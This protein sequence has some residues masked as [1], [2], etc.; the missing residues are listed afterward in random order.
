M[1]V[2]VSI[3][4]AVARSRAMSGQVRRQA[5]LM[6]LAVLICLSTVCRK[7]H[8]VVDVACGTALSL[9]L[10]VVIR[11]TQLGMGLFQADPFRRKSKKT[12]LGS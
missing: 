5:A 11:R 4:L 6:V 9:A 3:A 2:T 12:A 8:S 1:F 10:D 7:Q